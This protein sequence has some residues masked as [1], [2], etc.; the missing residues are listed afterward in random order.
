[1]KNNINFSFYYNILWSIKPT[2]I[3]TI[4]VAHNNHKGPSNHNP[5]GT[6]I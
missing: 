2:I 1:M 5:E 3:N 6:A 4:I